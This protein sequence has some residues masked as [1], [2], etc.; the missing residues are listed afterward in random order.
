M[1]LDIL[2]YYMSSHLKETILYTSV[3]YA[4]C[5]YI[6][7]LKTI[8]PKVLLKSFKITSNNINIHFYCPGP[9]LALFFLSQ[10]N[11]KE[12]SIHSVNFR[13]I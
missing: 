12:V 7:F 10:I 9:T 2:A 13:L 5:H 8:P 6:Y 4:L 3:L 11:S 1:M